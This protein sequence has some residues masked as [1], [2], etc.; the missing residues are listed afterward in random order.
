MVFLGGADSTDLMAGRSSSHTRGSVGSGL[1]SCRFA[2][3]RKDM[4]KLL[5]QLGPSPGKI[6]ARYSFYKTTQNL[7]KVSSLMKHMSYMIHGLAL[8]A[9]VYRLKYHVCLVTLSCN[10]FT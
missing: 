10:F 1:V 2:G 3:T 9:S 7:R 4:V 8:L 5:S 6:L